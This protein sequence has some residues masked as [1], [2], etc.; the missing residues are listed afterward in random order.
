VNGSYT[1]L[2]KLFPK[3]FDFLGA[4]ATVLQLER[5]QRSRLAEN[6]DLQ[7]DEFSISV[8]MAAAGLVITP[9]SSN[10]SS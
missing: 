3:R 9:A 5:C 2:V 6:L 7:I 8:F 1:E 10:K 4:P